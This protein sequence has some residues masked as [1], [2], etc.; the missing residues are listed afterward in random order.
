MSIHTLLIQRKEM[1]EL[2]ATVHKKF[3]LTDGFFYKGLEDA[4]QSLVIERQ[5]YQEHLLETTFTRSYRYN[6]NY[7]SMYLYTCMPSTQFIMSFLLMQ[8]QNTKVLCNSLVQ[9]ARNKDT[10]LISQAKAI[11]DKFQ[12]VLNL[13]SGCHTIYNSKYVSDSDINQLGKKNSTHLVSL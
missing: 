6:S 10:S 9:V 12:K 8:P 2:T 13:F 3:S 11:S 5:A 4:L 7:T 1:K